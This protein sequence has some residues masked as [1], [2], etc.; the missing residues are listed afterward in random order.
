MFDT[1][2]AVPDDQMLSFGADLLKKGEVVAFPTETVYGLGANA[3]D[4][5]AVH[6][7]FI[8]KNRPADNPLIVHVASETQLYDICHVT[9]KAKKL[10]THF[11]PGPLTILLK[12]KECIPS[13]VTA[14]LDSV[15]VRIPKHPLALKLLQTVRLPI[16]APSAN[17]S[18]RP[19]P[20]TAQDVYEDMK[21]RIPMILDGG[22]CDVGVESTVLDLT[23]GT[24][25]ILRPGAVTKE[26][27]QDVLQEEVQVAN[28]VLRPLQEG[29]KA[30]S[31]GMRYKH[32]APKGRMTIVLGEEQKV[33]QKMQE[34]LSE[35]QPL[36]LKTC[37]FA[38]TK[39][40]HLF[41][42]VPCFD[43]GTND[44][45]TAH[46]IFYYLRKADLEHF[47]RILSE[48]VLSQGVGLAVMNR[49]ARAAGFD[50]INV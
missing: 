45:D 6:K 19:S 5:Q 22:M 24:P 20:T 12:K 30:L 38:F 10:I 48:G 8:A 18:T 15:G 29:E 33:I 47:D 13:V 50:I 9:D 36:H 31:P 49:M 32:Y 43:L 26:M 25:I 42:H 28:S 3:L 21:G 2:C 14:G 35:E 27:L 39:H 16:A 41:P 7:I 23:H 44:V 1:L 37:V 17:L 34:M 11:C 46:N 4:E 40:L